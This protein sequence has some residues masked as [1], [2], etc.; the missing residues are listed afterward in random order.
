MVTSDELKALLAE[1]EPTTDGSAFAVRYI[2]AGRAYAVGKGPNGSLALFT[3]P[4]PDPEPPTRLRHLGLDP[5]A[6]CTLREANGVATTGYR[7]VVRF[8][9][10][11]EGLT[12][13]FLVVAASFVCLLG[14]APAPGDVSRA[15]RRL[16]RVFENPSLARKSALGLFG[17]LLVI[18]RSSHPG[19]L[20]DA[21]HNSVDAKFDFA[22]PG[23]RVEVKATTL[24]TRIHTFDLLQLKEP[25]GVSVQIASIMTTE[26]DSGVSVSELVERVVGRLSNDGHRQ[27]KVHETVSASLGPDWA[28]ASA[29]RFDETQALG[30]MRLL[31]ASSVPQTELPGSAVLRVVL[32]VDCT[33]IPDARAQNAIT[34]L[35]T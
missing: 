30:S 35:L 22:V 1:V 16:V 11:A 27:M 28:S 33:D 25:D 5:R 12:E 3:P 23:A 7:G 17:E 32:T 9:G 2:G 14:D 4:D 34:A 31:D 26:T 19:M 21:W 13:A 10:G 29:T 8:D 24:P 6:H 15:M 20:V 18:S